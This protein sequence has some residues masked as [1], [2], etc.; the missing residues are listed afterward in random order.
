MAK[1]WKNWVAFFWVLSYI[2]GSCGFMYILISFLF[3]PNPGESILI[4]QL[5]LYSGI[6]M[7]GILGRV[8]DLMI[9][10]VDISMQAKIKESI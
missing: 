3:I 8:Y 1:F 7:T 2:I 6:I 9:V 10:N 4:G 5:I